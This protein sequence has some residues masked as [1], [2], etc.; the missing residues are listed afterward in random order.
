VIFRR[1]SLQTTKQIESRVE[2]HLLDR[3]K[4]QYS[5]ETIKTHTPDVAEEECCPY[6]RQPAQAPAWNDVIN[7]QSNDQW[8]QKNQATGNEDA[9]VTS[10]M[11]T[12]KRFNLRG[13][14]LKFAGAIHSHCFEN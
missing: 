8:I 7:Q 11:Q 4:V 5:R 2:T 1:Q 10:N 6:E 12:K 9:Q 13:E 14:P 3:A